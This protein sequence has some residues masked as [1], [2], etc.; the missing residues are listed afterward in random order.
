VP[1]SPLPEIA[2]A[3][4]RRFCEAQVPAAERDQLRVE[5]ETGG[6][7]IT[8][9]ETRPPYGSTDDKWIREE[10]A[11][12][13]YSPDG[14]QW[15]LYCADSNGRWHRYELTGPTTRLQELIDE[16]ERDPTGIFW[17]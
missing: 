11:Q 4:I 3:A 9:Y 5:C 10:V 8:I 7:S 16:I 17:G 12:L 15:Q 2:V 1:S 6:K 14:R 13:R